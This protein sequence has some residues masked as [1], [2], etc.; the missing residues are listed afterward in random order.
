L[1]PTILYI[2][3]QHRQEI[4]IDHLDLAATEKVNRDAGVDFSLPGTHD[5]PRPQKPM[6]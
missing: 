4:P 6:Y 3:D 1:T 2:L 5:N